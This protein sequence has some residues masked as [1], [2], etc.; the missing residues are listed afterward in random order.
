MVF[1]FGEEASARDAHFARIG[2]AGPYAANLRRADF[3]VA[4]LDRRRQFGRA[5]DR[6]GGHR[7]RQLAQSDRVFERDRL[8]LALLLS[9]IGM[10]R[11]AA[12]SA[13]ESHVAPELL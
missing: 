3:V 10:A 4:K 9:E 2:V 7:R 5:Q 8:A 13:D 12:E 11:A 6:R 1:G